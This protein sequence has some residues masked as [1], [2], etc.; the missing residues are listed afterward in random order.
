MDIMIKYRND[1]KLEGASAAELKIYDG[2]IQALMNGLGGGNLDMELL[3]YRRMRAAEFASRD[4]LALIDKTIHDKMGLTPS[5]IGDVNVRS[6]L[7]TVITVSMDFNNSTVDTLYER[8]AGALGVPKGALRLIRT[9][10]HLT[11]MAMPL[12][13]MHML[14]GET[15]GY[16]M[17]LGCNGRCCDANYNMLCDWVG[18][19]AHEVFKGLTPDEVHRFC[20]N[21]GTALSM[22][23][24]AR[25]AA[26]ATSGTKHKF[27]FADEPMECTVKPR[28][29]L[30]MPSDKLMEALKALRCSTAM[31]VGLKAFAGAAAAADGDESPVPPPPPGSPP[32]VEL[33]V[34]DLYG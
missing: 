23:S 18:R 32:T 25:T 34:E 12:S 5:R 4:E 3:V 2:K 19:Q 31:P 6:M 8:V 14:P 1:R 33:H 22:M 15:I 26:T 28:T 11:E 9:G 10:K 17:K 7:G 30:L 21:Y 27:S 24:K 29:E 13:A 16:C 20:A